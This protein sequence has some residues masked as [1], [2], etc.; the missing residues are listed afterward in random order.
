MSPHS[1]S[2][3]QSVDTGLSCLVLLARFF[4]IPADTGQLK[5]QFGESGKPFGETELLRAALH[6]GLKTGTHDSAWDRL[7]ATPLPAI[8]Q[9]KDGRYVILARADAERALIQDPLETAPQ[10][11]PREVFEASWNGKLLLFTKRAQL[12]P[13]D[14]RFDF[15]W[16][17]PA[18]VKHRK[19]FGE[20]L[21]ASFFLQLF[22]LLTPLFFQVV[23][24]KVLVHKALT[25]LHV[26]GFGMLAMILFET[27]L[28]GLR[29]YV[30]SHTTSRLD[31][32]L[33][34]E[35]FRHLVR[36]PLAYFQARRVGDT[37]ARVRELETIRQFL[38]G[39]TV[40]VVIDLLF[41]VVF[42]A[43]LFFYSGWLTLVVLATIPFYVFLSAT[44]TPVFRARLHEKFNRGA[45][46]QSFLVETVNGI[47]TVKAMAV[48]P[49]M[50]RR[51]DE[52]LA[53]YVQA[54]FRTGTLGN[55]AGQIAAFLNK[56]TTVAIL[57]IGAHLVMSGDLSI[58]QLI[59]FNM[60]AGRVSGPLLRIVQLWQEFQQAG[61]SLQRLGDVLN[62]PPEPSY[63]PNRATLPSLAGHI[64][65]DQATFRYRPDG[66]EILKRLSLDIP[67]GQTI[68]V[69]GRSGSGKST[70]AKLVQRLY[71]PEAG[72]VL[73]D[74]V[75][76]AQIDPAWLRRQIGVVLQENFLFNRSV[77][78]NI[79]LADPGMPLERVIEAAKLAGAHDFILEMQ[80]GYDTVVGEHGC[81]LSGGQ[82]QRIAIARALVTDPK[83]LI[84]DEATS[85]LD[86]ESESII[87][88][89]L[90]SI[91]QG[92]T[93]IIIAHRLSTVR[94][95]DRIY[96]LDKGQIIEQGTHHE[97]LG[98][99]GYYWQLHQHQGGA[100]VVA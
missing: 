100:Y 64:V 80:Q 3:A 22:A 61:I 59:A 18:I 33:G 12:R 43:V 69:V 54:S 17:I 8:A 78:D 19:L 79:A 73:V 90:A 58:G 4:G 30:F 71:V 88:A 44:V 32:T 70:V 76:L 85:A 53:G 6:L 89:N 45:E 39:T 15:T 23:I 31:V 52:Q 16:F 2:A 83:L 36:L 7:A 75:D 27:L 98:L 26:I 51:W 93:V 82:R 40:T 74:G 60:L 95:A 77:R 49:A 14:R 92:R 97:L 84:F 57:W 20:V 46:N 94:S 25:T 24:D 29:T 34:A 72:R 68:G 86:Y 50:Q 55:V 47:E 87:Q 81:T 41:T 99:K 48:E 1:V 10:A 13:E 37:V 65:F 91:C 63:N 62:T 96:V 35:L 66:P 67:A 9:Y 42:I 5:H 11:L 56:L 38:T 21:A 28:G